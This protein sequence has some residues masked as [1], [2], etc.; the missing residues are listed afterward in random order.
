M[1]IDPLM[2]SATRFNVP[3]PTG[4]E[5]S[6]RES[7]YQTTDEHAAASTEPNKEGAASAAAPKLRPVRTNGAFPPAGRFT[8]DAPVITGESK[9]KSAQPV[10]GTSVRKTTGEM[11]AP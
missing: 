3:L 7:E 4:D 1:P 5:Q 9:V 2:L 8:T 11:T 10:P 6:T